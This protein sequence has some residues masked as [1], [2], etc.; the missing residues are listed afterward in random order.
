MLEKQTLTN[1]HGTTFNPKL[2]TSERSEPEML[3]GLT[4]HGG[5]TAFE[6]T[7]VIHISLYI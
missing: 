4:G 1:V 2:I 3:L 5:V 7:D 6:G